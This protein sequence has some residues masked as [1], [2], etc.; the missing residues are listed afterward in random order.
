[1]ADHKP[2][3]TIKFSD[4]HKSSEVNKLFRI[5]TTCQ[6]QSFLTAFA[7]QDFNVVMYFMNFKK[8]V[9]ITLKKHLAENANSLEKIR[10]L[11]SN[12]S[13]AAQLQIDLAAAAPL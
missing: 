8:G 3:Q 7:L 4:R 1:M 2:I 6:D 5:S 10:S 12:Q 11:P 9:S 13:S